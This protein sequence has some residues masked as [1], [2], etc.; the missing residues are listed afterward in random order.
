MNRGKSYRVLTVIFFIAFISFITRSLL[1]LFFSVIMAFIII[2][3]LRK[4]ASKRKRE[5]PIFSNRRQN[6]KSSNY[7]LVT[8]II[9]I[10]GLFMLLY[11]FSGVFLSDNLFRTMGVMV[12]ELFVHILF[13]LIGLFLTIY[14]LTVILVSWLR[15]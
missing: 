15:N 4:D 3:L 9:F 13:L 7:S 5:T 6:D 2:I 12:E 14:S 1:Y 10:I 8:M 11:G